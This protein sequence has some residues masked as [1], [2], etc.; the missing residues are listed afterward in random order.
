MHVVLLQ[1]G[2]YIQPLWQSIKD[3]DPGSGDLEIWNGAVEAISTLGGAVLAF[4]FAYIKLNWALVGELLLIVIS[5]LDGILL[6]LMGTCN[7]VWVSR[8]FG[9]NPK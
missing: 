6:I 4:A 7:N 5:M 1:V 3:G 2:N 8:L 9:S